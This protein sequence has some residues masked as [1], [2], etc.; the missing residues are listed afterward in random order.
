MCILRGNESSDGDGAVV[1]SLGA[2]AVDQSL[3]FARTDA[4]A[5]TAAAPASQQLR[6]APVAEAPEAAAQRGEQSAVEAPGSTHE[7]VAVKDTTGVEA[8]AA[9]IPDGS[10]GSTKV[11]SCH[12]ADL[13]NLPGGAGQSLLHA[14]VAQGA[15]RKKSKKRKKEARQQ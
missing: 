9:Y 7:T 14:I 13:S 12:A 15:E 2:V 6:S 4:A 10:D 1:G 3:V 11:R 8:M 5:S